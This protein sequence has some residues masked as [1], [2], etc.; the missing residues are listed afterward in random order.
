MLNQT[1]TNSA[2]PSQWYLDATVVPFGVLVEWNFWGLTLEN[3]I[4]VP[5]S[6]GLPSGLLGSRWVLI[7]GSVPLISFGT[8]I[9]W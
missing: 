8:V 7:D 2:S 4:Q 3:R 9:R 5:Y 1:Y 6:L